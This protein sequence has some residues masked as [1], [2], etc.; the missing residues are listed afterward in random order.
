MESFFRYNTFVPDGG[1]VSLGG[2]VEAP[3]DPTNPRLHLS[4]RVA[5][6]ASYIYLEHYDLMNQVGLEVLRAMRAVEAQK[7]MPLVFVAMAAFMA[8]IIFTS[9]FGVFQSLFQ[10]IQARTANLTALLAVSSMGSVTTYNFGGLGHR[11]GYAVGRGGSS[12]FA[13]FPVHPGVG[14]VE[15]VIRARSYK[16][17]SE[18]AKEREEEAQEGRGRLPPLSSPRPRRRPRRPPRRRP[19]R[20][21]PWRPKRPSTSPSPPPAPPCTPSAWAWWTCS[22]RPSAKPWASPRR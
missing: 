15:R 12:P 22:R 21:L 3:H 10:G 4:Y 5:P 20:P 1:V 13:L 14:G 6:Y 19:N 7:A 16:D 8:Y 17:I 18:R 2:P 9:L 11:A